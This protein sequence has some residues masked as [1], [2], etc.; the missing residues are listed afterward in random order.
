[1]LSHGGKISLDRKGKKDSINTSPFGDQ[2][3]K[4]SSI[5]IA[6][7]SVPSWLRPVSIHHNPKA[8]Q[9]IQA[10]D[11]QTTTL[12]EKNTCIYAYTNNFSAVNNRLCITKP[13]QFGK[14]LRSQPVVSLLRGFAIYRASLYP[15][16]IF[17]ISFQGIVLGGGKLLAG[18][19]LTQHPFQI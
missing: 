2:P 16:F 12:Q 10:T 9:Y 3:D 17:G 7:S 11:N 8:W 6:N 5:I 18:T 19:L 15:S 1:L 4:T 13:L 14:C